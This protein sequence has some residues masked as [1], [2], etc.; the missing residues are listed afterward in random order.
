MF[1]KEL[2]DAL[3]IKKDDNVDQMIQRIDATIIKM[4]DYFDR[5]D[6]SELLREDTESLKNIVTARNI[7]M[8]ESNLYQEIEKL[9]RIL[10]EDAL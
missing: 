8:R 9:K 2:L 5:C 4:L 1:E 3:D 10:Q 6:G 7:L